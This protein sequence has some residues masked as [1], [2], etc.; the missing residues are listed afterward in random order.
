ML[1]LDFSKAFDSIWHHTTSKMFRPSNQWQWLVNY[2]EQR[3]HCT[4]FNGETSPKTDM[5]ASVVQGPG[6]GPS[7]YV[8]GAFDLRANNILNIILKYPDDSYLIIPSN[9]NL[10][11]NTSKTKELIIHRPKATH[12]DPPSTHP[13]RSWKSALAHYIRHCVPEWLVIQKTREASCHQMCAKH[14][15]HPNTQSARLAGWEPLECDQLNPRL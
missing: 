15:R 2:L 13:G 11:L 14:L 10:K 1:A 8:I 5:N 7:C 3:N 9:N 6:I 12:P 4:K